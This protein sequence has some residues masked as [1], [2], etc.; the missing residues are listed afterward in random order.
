MRS[1]HNFK[2]TS[3]YLPILSG[4]L[5]TDLL[6]ILMLIGGIINSKVLLRWYKELS[7][8]AVIADVLIIV[9]GITFVRFLYPYIFDKYSLLKFL[10]LAVVIQVTHDILF[11]LFCTSVKRGKS[12]ILDIFKDYG[13]EKGSGAIV[14]DSLMMISSILI[15]S[16]LK[17]FSLNA[18]II[19]LII[20]VYIVPYFIYSL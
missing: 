7:L 18:N 17:G 16:Y 20:A 12:K 11:Y 15:A 10:L 3:D 5:I 9:L 2:D 1:I 19:T 4:V 6:V 14:A 13:L 8:S